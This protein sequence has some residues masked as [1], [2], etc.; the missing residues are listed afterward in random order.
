M[1]SV[2]GEAEEWS[3]RGS[4]FQNSSKE[5]REMV[6]AILSVSRIIEA[7][8]TPVPPANQK[9]RICDHGETP[10]RVYTPRTPF[11]GLVHRG[12]KPRL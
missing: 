11:I 1:A 2:Q 5:K 10:R 8:A 3:S 9:R 4:W 12:M 7:I 6:G